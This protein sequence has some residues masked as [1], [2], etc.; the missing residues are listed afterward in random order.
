V[1]AAYTDA[2]W[3]QTAYFPKHNAAFNTWYAQFLCFCKLAVVPEDCGRINHKV[4][5]DHS[6][7]CVRQCYLYAHIAFVVDYIALI[8]IT[9]CD[10][11]T[12]AVQ[13][14]NN[15]EHAAA[16]AADKMY[17]FFAV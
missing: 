7:C 2:F 1:G 10:G 4:G 5:T 3:E 16:A 9:A 14:L 8:Y 15:G 6:V 11:V 17:N 13:Y 12:L